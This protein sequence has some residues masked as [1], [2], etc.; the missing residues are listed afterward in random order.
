[1]TGANVPP[2]HRHVSSTM[3]ADCELT[4]SQFREI[5]GML[6]SHA[7]IR[8]RDGKE[9]FVRARLVKRLRRYG[10]ADFSSYLN[11]L[12]ADQSGQ[13]FIEMIDALTTNKTSF[14]REPAHFEY[15]EQTILPKVQGDFRVWCAGCSTGEEAY[16]LAMVIDNGGKR[17]FANTTSILATDVSRRVVEAAQKGQY[18]EDAIAG[19]PPEWLKKYW[20]RRVDAEGRISYDASTQI[21]DMVQ[22]GTLNLMEPWPMQGMFDVIMCRNVMIYF[23]KETQQRLIDRFWAMIRPGG[24]LLVGHSESLTGLSHRFRYVQPAVYAK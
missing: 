24:Q 18:S 13:E 4:E 3:L 6:Y 7:G 14:L 12:H 22:F 17:R 15:L 11:Y 8:M 20:V 5:A 16:T 21:R 2:T 23:D 10:F 19:V 1:M 9:G